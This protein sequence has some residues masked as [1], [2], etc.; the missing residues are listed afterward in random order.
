M[1]IDPTHIDCRILV[2]ETAEIFVPSL[3]DSFVL[4]EESSGVTLAEDVIM[5][6]LA[7]VAEVNR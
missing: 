4:S 6:P 5:L 1:G 2:C 7:V 3:F